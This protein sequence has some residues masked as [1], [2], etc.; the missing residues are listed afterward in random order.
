MTGDRRFTIPTV[1]RYGTGPASASGG[2]SSI[3]R[4]CAST[5]MSMR[6]PADSA[7]CSATAVRSLPGRRCVLQPRGPAHGLSRRCQ[8]ID[9][10][11]GR[12]PTRG[13]PDSGGTADNVVAF[14]SPSDRARPGQELL[15][16]LSHPLGCPRSIRASHRT[17]G[18]NAKRLGRHCR[19]EAEVLL[20]AVH[21]RFRRRSACRASAR[22]PGWRRSSESRGAIELAV[23]RPQVQIQG[24]RAQ[25]DLR[26]TDDGVEPIDL[27]L[28]LRLGHEALTETWVYQWTP[29]PAAE[30]RRWLAMVPADRAP[31]PESAL[32]R[33]PPRA[34]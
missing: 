6:N 7:C 5:R 34:R 11:E 13:D 26:T 22:T 29:P 25:F 15:V 32:S 1:W 31:L 20:V 10:G 24:Y 12:R 30:Q 18:R 4:E 14:W 16:C 17:G 23:P 8:D 9:A 27:R 2:R 28:Y 21:D 19:A 3:L 33:L